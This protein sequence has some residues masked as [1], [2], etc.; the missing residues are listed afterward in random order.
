MPTSFRPYQPKQKL[1]LPP[2]LRDWLPKGHLAY[3]VSDLVDGLDLTAFYAP[4]EGD[5]RRNAP[6]EPRMLV[7]LLIYGYATGVFSSRKIAKKLEEDV[8]FR[9]LAAGNFPKHRTICEFRRRHLEDFRK[10]FLE[11]IGLVREMGLAK[12]G[13]LSI[14]GTKV[15]ANASK[16][17]AMTYRRMKR[18]E[19]RL[20]KEIG[21]WLRRADEID[22]EEDARYG[23][24]R[25][26]DELP[27]EL[28]SRKDRLAAIQ[29]AK[30]RL[31]AAQRAADQAR[32]RKPGQD[33]NPKGGR[34]YKRAYGEPGP[35][36]QSN[37]TD[38]QSRIMKTSTEGFQQCYNAQVT[39][40]GDHQLIVSTAVTDNASDQ[41]QMIAQLDAVKATYEAQ[42][43]TILADADYGNERDLAELEARG[44]DGYV[45]LGRE[46]KKAR[47]SGDCE[48]APATWRMAKKLAT[49]KGR[50][51]YGMRKWISEAPHGWIKEVLGFRRFSVRGLR[52]VQG[53]WDLVCLALNVKRLQSLMAT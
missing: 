42:P 19:R 16:R 36:A 17:K 31:E 9:M 27:E 6:Y 51:T 10:L 48:K 50:A 24:D 41:G 23:Q 3:Q 1:L 44:I 14:D 38:P 20:E 18:E 30:A 40:E 15:R 49:E 12:L 28:R 39:V 25:R 47:K 11:V 33:R 29:A 46:G 13:K 37:F 45:A 26:G 32:G 22:G 21:D 4:Y 8:A 52:K 5:G 35:K 7:K 53:E 34:R 43:E 2:D